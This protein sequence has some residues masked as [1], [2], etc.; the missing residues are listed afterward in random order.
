MNIV[1]VGNPNQNNIVNGPQQKKSLLSKKSSFANLLGSAS[2]DW[3]VTKETST[4]TRNTLSDD[5]RIDE[6][7]L[8]THLQ[9]LAGLLPMDEGYLTK[10]KLN[11]KDVV[12]LLALLP[13]HLKL[14]VE[15]IFQSGLPIEALLQSVQEVN[16]PANMLALLI[17]INRLTS[18]QLLSTAQEFN[19]FMRHLENLLKQNDI[20]SNHKSQSDLLRQLIASLQK[21]EQRN[22]N[23][24][25]QS[26]MQRVGV[27]ERNYEGQQ[28]VNLN[29]D[30]QNMSRVQQLVLHIGEQTSKE[31]EQRQ[32]VRQF[33]ELLGRGVLKNLNNGSQISIRFFPEHLGR[34]D[35]RLSQMNGVITARILATTSTARELIESQIQQLR[36]GFS[37]QQINVERI[38]IAHQQSPGNLNKDGKGRDDDREQRD[39]QDEDNERERETF[40]QVLEELTINEKV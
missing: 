13:E 28:S 16:K 36:N 5:Q 8:L 39:K 27:S 23:Q 38:E 19:Q 25:L 32:F 14:E 35:I 17:V 10:E 12:D 24:I 3:G 21:E 15:S 34:L 11:D 1:G 6:A 18:D 37:Q 29:T 26:V 40:S 2:S 7:K 31:A 9:K 22:H 30:L 20:I 33:Q 4:Y